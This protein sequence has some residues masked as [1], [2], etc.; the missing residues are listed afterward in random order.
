MQ[1]MERRQRPRQF[2][3]RYV[4]TY[5][6][7]LND[8][9]AASGNDQRLQSVELDWP[10]AFVAHKLHFHPD[11]EWRNL[12][13]ARILTREPF[14]AIAHR[15]DVPA[16]AIN[17]Y[18]K[19][20]FN[21]CDR[22]NCRDW[23]AKIVRGEPG[24]RDSN[25]HGVMTEQQRAMV[26]RGFGFYGG[27]LVLDAIVAALSPKGIS[28]TMSNGAAWC[29]EALWQATRCKAA[30]AVCALEFDQNNAMQMLKL[31][32]HQ[33]RVAAGTNPRQHKTPVDTAKNIEAFIAQFS[34]VSGWQ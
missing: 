33:Q 22:L 21:V 27:P 18:E 14:D 31:W 13:Q 11:Q 23:I 7:F 25:R 5:W 30:M 17:C 8:Y 20:F 24:G 3:D 15:F 29:D 9:L 16:S 10:D 32:M 19:L 2:D 1:L 6:R 28:T 26:Y 4:R 12:L 34:A